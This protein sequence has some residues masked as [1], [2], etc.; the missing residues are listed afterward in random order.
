MVERQ[1]PI[2]HENL[3]WLNV[4]LLF[5]KSCYVVAKQTFNAEVR[6]AVIVFNQKEINYLKSE[7]N[8]ARKSI[9]VL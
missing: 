4:I 9:L 6:K 1:K 5:M 3:Y 2:S 8:F 7:I